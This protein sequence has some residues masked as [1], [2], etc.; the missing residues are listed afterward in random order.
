MRIAINIL[1]VS[2]GLAWFPLMA[3]QDSVLNALKSNLNNATGNARIN[4]LNNLANQLKNKDIKEA[5][6][7]A[8]EA[9][10]LSK[11]SGYPS[12]MI[13]SALLLGAHERNR[14]NFGK[15]SGYAED[16]IEAS[17]KINDKRSELAFWDL[18]VGIYRAA[19]RPKK[20]ADA[21]L[22]Y[23][24]LKNELDLADQ[25]NRLVNLKEDF[26]TTED[27]L[28]KVSLEKEEISGEKANIERE[29]DSTIEEKLE[30]EAQLAIIAAEKAQLE[31]DTL[32]LKNAQFQNE[33]ELAQKEKAIL[34]Y[35]SKLKTTRFFQV[36]LIGG[37]VATLAIIALMILIYRLRKQQDEERAI[38]QK[39]IQM[40]E[41][42][43]TLGQLTAGIAHE[44]KNPLNF[45]NNFAEG[46]TFLLEELNE[47]LDESKE[48]LS[49]EQKELV[50]ELTQEL[51]QN[52]LDILHHGKRV[53]RIVKGMMDHTRTGKGQSVPTDL[54]QLLGDNTD[55]A[56]HG[57]R[58]NNPDFKLEIEKDFQE[59]LPKIK[60]IPQDLSRVFI[61]IINN[62]CY[63]VHEKLKIKGNDFKSVLKISTRQVNNEIEI[64]IYDNGTGIPEEARAKIFN[65]FFTTKPTG[66]G[67]TGLGLSISYDVVVQGHDGKLAVETEEG[68]FTE[69]I[70][71][72]PR[73]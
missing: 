23:Q 73:V 7:Y 29:L 22:A 13:R 63:A 72:L 57:Y 56:Y 33:L 42:M 21:D 28:N 34:E 58:A 39:Q 46:S 64:R 15:A 6:K 1:L 41:K 9:F 37:L 24:K 50:E 51:N 54:N 60:V 49:E 16:G 68:E 35:D 32:K 25:T 5:A 53:D 26:K 67:N 19:K 52:A 69:F 59:D 4:I 31:A 8:E 48:K 66:F 36:L 11:K 62:A 20:L 43:A 71:H 47:T 12:G 40:Q 44:I 65:P 38:L 14:R 17:K 61:N 3:Q 2:L 45:V 10:K 70:I 18:L 30:R 55:L 27:S